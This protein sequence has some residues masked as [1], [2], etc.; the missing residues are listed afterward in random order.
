[1]D[2]LPWVALPWMPLT[3]RVII[4]AKS[5][6]GHDDGGHRTCDH[7]ARVPAVQVVVSV[8]RQSGGYSSCML[9]WC[10][11]C[12]LR[13]KP[14]RFRRYSSWVCKAWLDSGYMFCVS[15]RFLAEFHAFLRGGDTRILRLI[16]SS[17]PRHS[18]VR[19]RSMHSRCFKCFLLSFCA[20][21]RHFVR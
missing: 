9:S 13:S 18:V 3:G 16:S 5:V 15:L 4:L 10:P 8:L 21:R 20:S 14:P 12:K 2:H 7:A 6:V 19:R 11:Q 17:S 1:M